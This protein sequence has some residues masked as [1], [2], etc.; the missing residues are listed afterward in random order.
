MAS[1]PPEIPTAAPTDKDAAQSSPGKLDHDNRKRKRNTIACFQVT[2][3]PPAGFQCFA[4]MRTPDADIGSHVSLADCYSVEHENAGVMSPTRRTAR[5][6]CETDWN[7]GGLKW[8]VGRRA[9]R[10][11]K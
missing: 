3:S 11:E 2:C 10:K 8:M 4:E 7:V 1:M 9:G 5:I 6:V